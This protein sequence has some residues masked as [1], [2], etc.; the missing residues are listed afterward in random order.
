MA[1][2]ICDGGGACDDAVFAQMFLERK[3]VFIDLLGWDLPALAGRFEVDQF[4]TP[5]TRYL[6]CAGAD[7]THLGSLRLLPCSGPTLLA[8]LFPYLC[9]GAP[10]N[11][12][13]IWEV[14]RL[15]LARHLPAGERRQ[16][17][18]QLATALT[19][20]ALQEGIAGYCCV[21]DRAWAE[22]I[23][24]F[25]WRCVPLGPMR[26]IASGDIVAL[27]IDIDR[28]TPALMQGAGVWA[29]SA[30]SLHEVAH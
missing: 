8:S 26:R 21:A 12:P 30:A 15:C 4:D 24:A 17:R 28:H 1:H 9:E 7:G 5:A 13:A 6:I 22:Q 18:D 23:G 16:V 3:R 29:P 11:D 14:S 2:I 27:R 19:L 25:G 10:P 20:I